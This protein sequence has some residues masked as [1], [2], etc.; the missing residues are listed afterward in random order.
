MK[1][2]THFITYILLA[3]SVMVAFMLWTKHVRAQDQTTLDWEIITART[4]TLQNIERQIEPL[5]QDRNQAMQRRCAAANL[6]PDTCNVDIDKRTATKK[7]PA[8][9][10]GK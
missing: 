10:A 3:L 9:P 7:E 1:Q 4:L 5:V 6:T 8:K 2:H